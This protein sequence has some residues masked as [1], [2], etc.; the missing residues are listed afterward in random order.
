M[1]TIRDVVQGLNRREGVRAV[2][3]LGR[4]GLTIDGATSDGLDTEGLAALIPSVVQTCDRLGAAA[5]QGEILVAAVEFGNGMML[6]T[7]LTPETVLAIFLRANTNMGS[8]LY[9]IRRHQPAIAG[10]L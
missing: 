5:E 1:P 7:G 3:V 4:D 8:L 9:E 10:L 6:L 2:I